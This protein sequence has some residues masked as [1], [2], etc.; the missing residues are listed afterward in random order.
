MRKQLFSATLGIKHF[1]YFAY[2]LVVRF[3]EIFSPVSSALS[4]DGFKF[5]TAHK[6]NKNHSVLI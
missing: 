1:K 6:L 4:S 2:L 3:D 5:E